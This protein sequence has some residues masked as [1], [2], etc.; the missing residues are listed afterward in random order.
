[1]AG[2]LRLIVLLAAVAGCA[3]PIRVGP[4][5]DPRAARE[6]LASA[7]AGG[8]VRLEVNGMVR[9]AD[10]TVRSPR[11]AEQAAR[12]VRGLNVRFAP[13]P[14]SAGSARLLLLFDPPAEPDIRRVC[15]A[16]TLPASVPS[17]EPL[18]LRA[19]C[20]DGGT[21][22]ADTEASTG[23]TNAADIDR[24]VWRAVGALFPDDYPESYG[25]RS[26]FGF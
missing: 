16:P 12:G 17:P 15:A 22:I 13:E 1:V 26:F 2:A 6:L 24:L 4:D 9:A 19:V 8:P 25:I 23:G 3:T 20:C 7:A 21:F 18:R 11:L 10:T 5:S 14:G